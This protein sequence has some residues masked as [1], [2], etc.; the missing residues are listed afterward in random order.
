MKQ[1]LLRVS[2]GVENL[3]ALKHGRYTR[4]RIEQARGIRA[5]LRQA[6]NLLNGIE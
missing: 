1:N 3:Y 5:L 2:E 6:R 4:E